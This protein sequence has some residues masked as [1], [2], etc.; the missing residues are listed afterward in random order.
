MT[1]ILIIAGSFLDNGSIQTAIIEQVHTFSNAQNADLIK[2]ILTGIS[3]T[4][5]NF[6]TI[7][8]TL[9]TLVLGALGVFYELKNL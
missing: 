9:S 3:E 5:F 8:I 6:F 4:K 1:L 7:L 2:S